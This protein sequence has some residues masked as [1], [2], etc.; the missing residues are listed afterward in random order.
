MLST[1]ASSQAAICS[2]V[3]KS[4]V[5]PKSFAPEFHR[6]F[7]MRLVYASQVESV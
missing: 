5:A 1:S 6:A 4:Q 3:G 2:G 7:G